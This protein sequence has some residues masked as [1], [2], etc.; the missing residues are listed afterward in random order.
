MKEITLRVP[1]ELAPELEALVK[2]MALV[3]EVEEY[4]CDNDYDKIFREAILELKEDH[5][6]RKP[7]D[8]AWIMAAVNDGVVNDA[9]PF[10]SPQDFIDY[11]NGLGID[12]LPCR[13]TLSSAYASIDGRFPSW[14]YGEL[15]MT[16]AEMNHRKDVVIR[17]RSAFARAKRRRL[18]KKMDN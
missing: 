14:S 2:K 7:R 4:I 15:L 12:N 5:V 10:V 6:I 9:E 11:L 8:Y 16:V 18:D 17:F 3:M 1:D 13:S